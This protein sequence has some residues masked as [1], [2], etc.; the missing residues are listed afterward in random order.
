MLD[1]SVHGAKHHSFNLS[2]NLELLYLRALTEDIDLLSPGRGTTHL[3]TVQHNPSCPLADGL[4]MPSG[5]D[6]QSVWSLCF[7]NSLLDV[8]EP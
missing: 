3:A 6:P 8:H 4:I 1:F 5:S 7:A 2:A